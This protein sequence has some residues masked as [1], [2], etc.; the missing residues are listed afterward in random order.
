MK[1]VVVSGS[2][3]MSQY[4]TLS[5]SRLHLVKGCASA[6]FNCNFELRVL[7]QNIHVV[8]TKRYIYILIIFKL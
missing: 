1:Q 4:F 7:Q 6:F 8:R 2:V 5:L 3:I